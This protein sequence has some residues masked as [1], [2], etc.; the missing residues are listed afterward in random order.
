MPRNM[1]NAFTMKS[2][3][4]QVFLEFWFIFDNYGDEKNYYKFALHFFLSDFFFICL[5]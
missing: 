3:E 5:R 4:Q 2:I 1:V